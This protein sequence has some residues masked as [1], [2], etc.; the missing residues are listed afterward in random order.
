MSATAS[1]VD[2]VSWVDRETRLPVT[3]GLLI[4]LVVHVAFVPPLTR[5]M[6]DR[7]A[8]EVITVEAARQKDASA[9][10]SPPEQTADPEQEE[11]RLGEDDA[12][13]RLTMSWIS[14]DDYRKL[15]ARQS[16][17]E[18]P[19][20][21]RNVDPADRAP[22]VLDPTPPMPSSPQA[23]ASVPA[24][25]M[26]AEAEAQAT[27]PRAVDASAPPSETVEDAV[28]E[29]RVEAEAAVEPA[30]TPPAEQ[31]ASETRREA[32]GEPVKQAEVLPPTPSNP[33]REESGVQT[34][35]TVTPEVSAPALEAKAE[36]EGPEPS[37]K[38]IAAAT[39]ELQKDAEPTKQQQA[40]AQ[41]ETAPAP[42]KPASAPSPSAAASQQVAS[43]PTA[44]AKSDKEA[45]PTS[46]NNE[47]LEGKLGGVLVGRGYQIQTVRPRF[48]VITQLSA[49]PRNPEVRIVFDA[50]GTVTEAEI[51][52]SSGYAGV[53]APLLAAMYK[54]R[55]TGK[56][57][58][59]RK[60]PL[61]LRIPIKFD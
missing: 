39:P 44:A 47:Q 17:V 37:T 5:M 22:V 48:S 52:K 34:A 2:Q 41:A 9:D 60:Q 33:A 49:I 54:W 40:P 27:V 61:E 20:V 12:P 26:V 36:N 1:Q 6:L 29:A 51:V 42:A 56:L 16:T 28:A 18:Q 11:V 24:P 23:Q 57:F 19:A 3:I 45:D 59:E 4:A 43:N 38:Q 46:K 14:H 21:Q 58:E 13:E 31:L 15:V 35:S 10:R 55:A 50:D 30:A 32:P 25:A 8:D 53:D 7:Q